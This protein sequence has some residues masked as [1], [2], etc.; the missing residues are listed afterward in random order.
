MYY[1]NTLLAIGAMASSFR[2]AGLLRYG[3]H[4]K[5]TPYLPRSYKPSGVAAAKRLSRKRK[6]IR[7]RSK[8]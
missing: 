5:G 3:A 4:T 6:N 8:K 7:K 2:G 1:D